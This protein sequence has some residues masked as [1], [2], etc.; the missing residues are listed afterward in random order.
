PLGFGNGFSCRAQPQFWAA[1]ANEPQSCGS[2]P[3]PPGG[4]VPLKAATRNTQW[5]ELSTN[6]LT[7]RYFALALPQSP[8]CGA[9]RAT[10]SSSTR[11]RCASTRGS[12]PSTAAK[13]CPPTPER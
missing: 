9:L 10:C 6:S 1:N 3:A 12:P 11:E 7:A 13:L 2:W 4:C 5:L 8:P